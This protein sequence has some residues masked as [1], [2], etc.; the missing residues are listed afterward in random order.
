MESTRE[1]SASSKFRCGPA[2]RASFEAGIKMATLY[3]QFV[4]TPFCESN[5]EEL[6]KAIEDCIRIQPYVEDA[7]VS[8]KAGKRNKEDQY[9]YHSL[10]GDM[11]DATVV[12]SVDG[13]SV[14]AEM[15]Y[16]E[17][18]KYPLMYISNVENR[19]RHDP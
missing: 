5:R 2:E 6:E 19:K 17:A 16:D 7:H 10:S 14:T 4:G 15:R 13:S 18:L 3:H 1:S 11:I 9:A 8:I 12:I